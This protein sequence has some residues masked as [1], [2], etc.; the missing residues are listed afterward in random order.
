MNPPRR[1]TVL[2]K[3]IDHRRLPFHGRQRG[4]GEDKWTEGQKEILAL[5]PPHAC[6]PRGRRRSGPLRVGDLPIQRQ[7][8][9]TPDLRAQGRP[10]QLGCRSAWAMP[11]WS[12][13]S[14]L[15]S[16]EQGPRPPRGQ[17]RRRGARWGSPWGRRS[18]GSPTGTFELS[19]Y[20]TV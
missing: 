15:L 8:C 18:L 4:R 20:I 13:N 2:A 6:Y 9:C 19:I 16:G 5:P 10:R 17:G 12:W 11:S 1:Y 14:S 7:A 3:K